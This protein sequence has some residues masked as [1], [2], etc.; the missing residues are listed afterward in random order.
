MRRLVIYSYILFFVSFSVAR[1]ASPKP[2]NSC[3]STKTDS[4]LCLSARPPCLGKHAQ[5]GFFGGG[6]ADGDM[7]ECEPSP[8]LT[9]VMISRPRLKNN[10]KVGLFRAYAYPAPYPEGTRD[11]RIR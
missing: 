8:A 10:P 4:Q 1:T 6:V 11:T 5:A 9:E 7:R 3:F 2:R